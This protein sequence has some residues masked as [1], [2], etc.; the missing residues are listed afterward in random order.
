MHKVTHS[1]RG[2]VGG[3]P[4]P[5]G[6]GTAPLTVRSLLEEPVMV[7]SVVLAGAEA[8]GSHVTWVRPLSDVVADDDRLDRVAVHGRETDL[9]ARTVL[10]LS[11]R[12]VAAVLVREGTG[13]RWEQQAPPKGLPVIGLAKGARPDLVARHVARLSLAHESHVLRYGQQVHSALAT[14]LHRGSGVGALCDLIERLSGCAVAVLGANMS[15]LAYSQ[16]RRTWLDPS[17]LAAVGRELVQKLSAEPTGSAGIHDPWVTTADLKGRAV[18]FVVGP[19][20]LA[21]TTE[22]WILLV[23]EGAPERAN[24]IA[25]HRI[26]VQQA[27]TII[28]TELLRVRGIERAEERARGNFVHALLHGRFSNHADLVARATHHAFPVD[29]RFGVVVVEAKGLIADDDSPQRLAAMARE[30]SRLQSVA[31][32]RTMAAVVGDVIAIVREVPP[33]PKSGTDTGTKELAA[34]SQAVA[35]RLQGQTDRSV[36]VSFGRPHS[37]AEEIHQAYREARIALGLATQ[38]GLPTPCGFSDL[39]VFSALLGLAQTPAG[40]E[41]TRD[42]VGPLRAASSELEAAVRAYVEAGGNL[43]QAARD[44]S[45]H[46]NTMLYRLERASKALDWDLRDPEARFAVWLAMKLDVLAT[47]ADLVARDIEGG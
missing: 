38:L 37:G 14:L 11:R 41:L 21:D 40:Q 39:R 46:R 23:D 1:E 12:G 44:L 16:G 36:L 47:T 6:A 26:V 9:D 7:G 28:G 24:A 29:G 34:F 45:I 43:N 30:A 5:E 32:R 4:A 3:S 10:E 42:L 27:S 8:L 35:R 31:E 19:I 17:N 13:P 15:L 22:G 2:S 18:T 25:E 20:E 33:A